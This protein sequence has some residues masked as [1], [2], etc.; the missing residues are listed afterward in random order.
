MGPFSDVTDRGS[1]DQTA[2]GPAATGFQVDFT[3]EHP[4]AEGF[5]I[6]SYYGAV[7][8]VHFAIVVEKQLLGSPQYVSALI[9]FAKAE[10]TS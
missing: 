9:G 5:H 10:R 2:L 3:D 7:G 4:G 8:E 6:P 1:P